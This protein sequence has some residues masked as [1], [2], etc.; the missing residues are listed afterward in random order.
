MVHQSKSDR[1]IYFSITAY[2]YQDRVGLEQILADIGGV[3]CG[4]V[5]SS[6][7]SK[8]FN[9]NYNYI[10]VWINEVGFYWVCRKIFRHL[11]KKWKCSWYCQSNW[12]KTLSHSFLACTYFA[13]YCFP[14]SFATLKLSAITLFGVK[15]NISTVAKMTFIVTAGTHSKANIKWTNTNTSYTLCS[16][17]SP[18]PLAKPSN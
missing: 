18:Q 13:W 7:K 3:H 9:S 14:C 5:A 1:W 11:I 2:P 12:I 16:F 6:Y 4:Q 15:L 17:V 8:H 10:K